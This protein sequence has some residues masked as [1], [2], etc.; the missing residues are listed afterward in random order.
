MLE[1]LL[2]FSKVGKHLR[3]LNEAV[4]INDFYYFIYNSQRHALYKQHKGT[5]RLLV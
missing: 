3:R 2:Y 5:N 1:N 4:L